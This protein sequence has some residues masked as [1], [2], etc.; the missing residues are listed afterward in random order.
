MEKDYGGQAY[1]MEQKVSSAGHSGKLHKFGGE[2]KW[3]K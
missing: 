2:K 3:S 1:L